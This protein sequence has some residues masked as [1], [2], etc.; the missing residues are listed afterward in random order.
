VQQLDPE[1]LLKGGY[2]LRDHGLREV[3]RAGRRR[4]AAEGGNADEDLHAGDPVEH[5]MISLCRYELIFWCRDYHTGGLKSYR[6]TIQEI[7][8]D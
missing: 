5:G 4:E 1:P 7:L 6:E 3:K 8:D 2:M